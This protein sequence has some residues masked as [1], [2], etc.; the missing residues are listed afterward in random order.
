MNHKNITMLSLLLLSQASQASMVFKPK[1]GVQFS[2]MHMGHNDSQ[3]LPF[4]VLDAAELPAE[5]NTTVSANS[6]FFG[7]V[8][9]RQ[10]IDKDNVDSAFMSQL[11]IGLQLGYSNE[12]AR[13]N[14]HHYFSPVANMY[15]LLEDQKSHRIQADRFVMTPLFTGG[16]D[17]GLQLAHNGSYF[18]IGAGGQLYRAEFSNGLFLSAMTRVE[19]GDDID[20]D[21]TLLQQST[22]EVYT[23][24]VDPVF[25]PYVY[26]E[27]NTE[28][29]DIL[30]VFAKA[31]YGLEASPS[32]FDDVPSNLEMFGGNADTFATNSKWKIDS[33]SIGIKVRFSDIL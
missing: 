17:I 23:A 33:A 13:P 15:V 2:Q 29:G 5:S 22:S 8:E 27:V 18:Q 10:S 30:S 6:A 1:V 9:N 26:S 19:S 7:A 20:V 4:F 31:T 28:I 25:L 3:N 32:T 12:P 21:T 14:D 24:T 11:L 16:V